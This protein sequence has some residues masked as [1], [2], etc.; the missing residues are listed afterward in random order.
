MTWPQY[1]ALPPS[2]VHTGGKQRDLRACGQRYL[3]GLA[4]LYKVTAVAFHLKNPK[5]LVFVFFFPQGAPGIP[6]NT[7]LS[8]IH[9]G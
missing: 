7:C 5:S 1:S 4:I 9:C 3:F 2:G 8:A 6:R